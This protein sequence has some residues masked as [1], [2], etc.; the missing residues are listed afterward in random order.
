MNEFPRLFATV[1][2]ILTNF[3]P[4]TRNFTILTAPFSE[5][6]HM[7]SVRDFHNDCPYEN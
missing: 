2:S 3:L 4:F 6:V 7:L 1:T 5:F